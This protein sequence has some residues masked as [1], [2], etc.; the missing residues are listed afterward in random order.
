MLLSI[1]MACDLINAQEIRMAYNLELPLTKKFEFETES[2]IKYPVLYSSSKVLVFE[3]SLKYKLNKKTDFAIGYKIASEQGHDLTSLEG[4]E[5]DKTR[6]NADVGYK[7]PV[8]NPDLSLKFRGR[9]QYSETGKKQHLYQRSRLTVK[10]NLHKKFQPYIS[11]EVFIKLDDTAFRYNRIKVGMETKLSK[12]LGLDLYFINEMKFK[13]YIS[14]Q[15]IAG[16]TLGIK[17]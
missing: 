9:V 16:L 4:A 14:M 12:N 15:Y 2:Q 8:N 11:D 5:N 6:I 3:N 13:T 7:I 1:I 17:I 10:Y